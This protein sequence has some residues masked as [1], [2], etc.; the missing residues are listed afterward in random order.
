NPL[1]NMVS[2]ATKKMVCGWLAQED[3]EDFYELCKDDGEVDERRLEFWLCFKEQMSYTMILLGTDLRYSRARDVT[4]FIARKGDRVGDL[5]RAQPGNNAILM[6]IGG[7]L[8][9]EFS[10][11]GNACFGFPIS[12]HRI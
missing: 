5:T 9:V 8:F 7:W 3:L 10:K 4:E 1:W 11:T 2:T 12:E 6:C